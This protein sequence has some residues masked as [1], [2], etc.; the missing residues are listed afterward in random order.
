ML[1]ILVCIILGLLAGLVPGLHANLLT[2][3]L[4]SMNIEDAALPLA[5]IAMF[6]AQAIT[7]YIPAIFLGIPDEQVVLSV[8]PGQRMAREGSGLDALVI[9]VVASIIAILACIALFPVSQILYPIVFPAIQPY[10]LHILVLAVLFLVLRSK[11]PLGYFLVFLAAGIIG[12]ESFIIKMSDPFLPMFSGMFAMAAI[13]TFSTSKIPEQKPPQKP[14][15]SILKFALIGVIFGWFS[16][17][18]PGIGSP[19]QVAAF[20]S[21]LVPFA[22]APSYLA[23]IS[24]IG[25]S[26]PI[27]ALSTAATIGKERV[28]SV[29]EIS[30]LIPISENLLPLLTFFIVGTVVACIFIMLFRNKIG[31]ISRIDYKILNIIIA[32]YLVAIVFLLDSWAGLLVFG[33]STLL[34]ILCIRSDV[35][36]TAMMGAIILPTILNLLF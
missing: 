32:I 9:M 6:G 23:T 12:R 15:N 19:A 31:E 36:R 33:V 24:S 14:D 11:K 16:D 7:A 35:E 26:Q 25:V 2:S 21:I 5:I 20:A 8:L 18:L 29:A 3:A 1:L 27:F 34:G 30:N 10:L 4:L 28:G 13:L 22:S 17:L